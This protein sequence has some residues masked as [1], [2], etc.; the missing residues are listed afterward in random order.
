MSGN[1]TGGCCS[2]QAGVKTSAET[3][4]MLLTAGDTFHQEP[5]GSRHRC[6]LQ[7]AM[8]ANL[9][10]PA[11]NALL[12]CIPEWHGHQLPCS[13]AEHGRLLRA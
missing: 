8:S 2:S 12:P 6:Q 1:A 13:P 4:N 3:S 11:A 5:G 9:R 7:L 10:R